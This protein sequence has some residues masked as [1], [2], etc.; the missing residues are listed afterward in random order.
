MIRRRA[1]SA[2]TRRAAARL[3]ASCV[4]SGP[5]KSGGHEIV[6]VWI[7][8]TTWILTAIDDRR[9]TRVFMVIDMRGR[10]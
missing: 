1:G 8:F 2:I 5:A 3:S 4:S 10:R 9:Q 7:V 6:T